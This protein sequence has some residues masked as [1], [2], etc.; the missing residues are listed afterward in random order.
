M[1]QLEIITREAAPGPVL[2]LLGDLDYD[3]A[4]RLREVLS[5]L[6]LRQGSRLVL[7]LGG[8][9]F[10]DSSGI[11]ALIVARNHALAAQAEVALADVP[12]HLM[13]VLRIVRLD[14]IFPIDP[15]SA[16]AM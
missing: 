5:S 15:G 2:E 6:A 7:D 13:R 1:S 12:D 10:C 16:A 4:G 8:V 14:Q 9:T 11:T 3:T